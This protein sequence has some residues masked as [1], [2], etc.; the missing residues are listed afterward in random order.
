MYRQLL[1]TLLFLAFGLVTQPV[2]AQ[3]FEL[4]KVTKE[5]LSEKFHP[6]DSAAPAAV[7]YERGKTY[8]KHTGFGWAVFIEVESRIKIYK[9]EGYK[10]AQHKMSYYS[11]N[12][13][14]F[15]YSDA[16]TYNLSGDSI[17]KTKLGPEGEFIEDRT[18]YT[19]TK[20]IVMPEVKEGS[21]IEYKYTK[22]S[23]RLAYLPNWY[24]QQDIPIKYSE[25]N[26]AIPD[27]F[28]Y[29]SI[30]TGNLNVKSTAPI[31]VLRDGFHENRVT[32]TVT[33]V[34]AAKNEPYIDNL[35]NYIPVI[36]HEMTAST[37]FNGEE[38][39]YTTSWKSLVKILYE[40]ESFGKQLEMQSYFRKDI[41]ALLKPDMTIKE[42]VEAIFTYVQSRM[43]WDEYI[44]YFCDE[45]VKKAYQKKKGNTAEINLML[46]AMLQYAGLPA[47]PVLTSTR[48][49]GIFSYPSYLSFNYVLASVQIGENFMLLDATSK[50]TVPGMLPPRALNKK[51]RR[52]KSNLSAVEID[53]TP[54]QGA[55]SVYNVFATIAADG[56]ISGKIRSQ[57]FDYQALVIREGDLLKK[58]DEYIS[59]LEKSL[60]GIEITD[61]TFK[62]DFP[63]PLIEEYSFNHT[64]FADML[65]GKIIINPMLF[66]A[67]NTNPFTANERLYPIDFVFSYQNKYLITLNLPAGYTV[68][69]FP[70]S[71]SVVM[72]ENVA[73][74]KYQ[75]DVKNNQLQLSV[76]FEVN[77]AVIEKENY[78]ALK[79]FYRKAVEKQNEKIILKKA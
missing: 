67:E 64:G 23:S 75:I 57:Y 56:S 36:K 48:S 8:F 55:K 28:A 9:K 39:R 13:D 68:E 77:K 51:G 22:A 35:E 12:A 45:G 44:G 41:D 73:N 72:G 27:Y 65:G 38:S 70:E 79:D 71:T 63:K 76:V 10:Y 60:S 34:P 15:V 20:K 53:L 14:Y 5:E 50:Y 24:L 1:Y 69:S 43:T 26:V 19:E 11:G 58:Q 33:G 18:K 21:V 74:F 46:T 47:E 31:N 62:N 17:V 32:Y 42:K 61:Y 7:L 66:F 29:R 3:Q 78:N 25:Y 54:K 30:I 4:G 37:N 49:N 40:D 2:T 16:Y 6:A 59:A 52:L